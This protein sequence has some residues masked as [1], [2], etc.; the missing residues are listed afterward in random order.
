MRSDK[1]LEKHLG[2]V[3]LEG[4]VTFTEAQK[5]AEERINEIGASKKTVIEGL[6]V[7]LGGAVEYDTNLL[8][9]AVE[10]SVMRDI[11]AGIADFFNWHSLTETLRNHIVHECSVLGL[12]QSVAF[13][14]A[15]QK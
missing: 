13:D 12:V 1:E 4:H 2:D 3:T 11:P 14:L 9:D 15:L 10:D 5:Y 7:V 6:S 8:F